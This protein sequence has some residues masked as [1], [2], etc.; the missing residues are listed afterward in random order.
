MKDA[1]IRA[2]P[3]TSSPSK[4]GVSVLVVVR[5]EPLDSILTFPDL[6]AQLDVLSRGAGGL[7]LGRH[8]VVGLAGWCCREVE[9]EEV[10][11]FSQ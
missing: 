1:K 4:G 6:R 2:T 9:V 3:K 10:Q 7:L 5:F 8:L 11:S